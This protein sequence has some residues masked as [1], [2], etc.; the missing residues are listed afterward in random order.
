MA[1]TE[2]RRQVEA[3]INKGRHNPRI[4]RRLKVRVAKAMILYFKKKRGEKLTPYERQ[5]SKRLKEGKA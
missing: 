1:K 5:A 3:L 2:L 4:P